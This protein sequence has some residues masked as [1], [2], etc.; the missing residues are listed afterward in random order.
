MSADDQIRALREAVRVSPD[1]VPLRSHL[2]DVLLHAGFFEEAEHEYRAAL[3]IAPESEGLRL[4]LAQTFWAQGKLAEASLIVEGLL[5]GAAPLAGVSLL[6][7]RLALR[8]RRRDEALALYRKALEGEPSLADEALEIELGLGALEEAQEIVE[9][10][11]RIAAG[12]GPI[13]DVP[14]ERPTIT[15]ADVGGMEPVKDAIRNKII[16]PMQNPELYRAYGKGIGG[17]LLLYGPPGCGKT[18][19]ARATA[20]E[21]KSSFISVGIQDVLDMWLGNSERNM[22][23]VFDQARRNTPCL[24]FFDEVDA[25]AGRRTDM[26]ASA[27]RNTVNVF[28]AEL[29]GAQQQNEG[30]LVIAATNAPWSVDSAFRR[31][32]RFDQVLFVP[33]PDLDARVAILRIHVKGKPQDA[34]DLESVAKKTEHFSGAD[35]KG[36]VDSAVERKLQVALKAGQPKPLTTKDLLTAAA[37]LRPSTREWF[38]TAK[39]YVLYSNQGGVYDD[40]QKYLKL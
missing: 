15:F 26:H 21:V 36:L 23:Q 32:G 4:S 3:A 28:L 17:G 29:D 16:F 6:A 11:V 25:L 19:L 8:D 7:A 12:G 33:P 27:G 31:P 10:K 20:G 30:V 9:G 37:A 13:L 24:L 1:N 22:H 38:A 5:E 35:L 34:L 18:H 40:V 14:L 2:A 39:N